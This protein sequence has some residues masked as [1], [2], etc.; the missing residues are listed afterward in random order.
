MRA[1][2]RQGER[3]EFYRGRKSREETRSLKGK[4]KSRT[5]TTTRTRTRRG[6]LG[7]RRSRPERDPNIEHRTSNA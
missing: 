6:A 4:G 5:R 3:K 1:A 7:L 2:E